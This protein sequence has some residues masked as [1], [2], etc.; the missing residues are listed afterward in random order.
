MPILALTPVNETVTPLKVHLPHAFFPLYPSQVKGCGGT[1]KNLMK[2]I[3]IGAIPSNIPQDA[4]SWTLPL[5]HLE[6]TYSDVSA[7]I[8]LIKAS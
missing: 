8:Y 6:V 2:E 4:K 3:P 5:G 1:L 7:F